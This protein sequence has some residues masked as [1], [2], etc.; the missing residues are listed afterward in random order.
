MLTRRTLGLIES[1]GKDDAALTAVRF[2]DQRGIYAGK[3]LRTCHCLAKDFQVIGLR[4]PLFQAGRTEKL[5]PDIP[6]FSW[7]FRTTWY[8]SA[9][10]E[11]PPFCGLIVAVAKGTLRALGPVPTGVTDFV[12]VQYPG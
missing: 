4:H 9:I 8:R 5:V 1:V 7:S 3:I 6:E 12:S 2:V 11:S 10:G